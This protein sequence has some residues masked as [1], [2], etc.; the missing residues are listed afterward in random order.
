M[1]RF[2]SAA[3]G[4]VADRVFVVVAIIAFAAGGVLYH[5]HGADAVMAALRDDV[6][7]FTILL[8]FV[9]AVLL[10]SAV[11]EV[12]MPAGLVERWIGAQSGLRGI[13][14][15]TLA[16]MFTPGGPFVAFPLVLAL[17]RAGADYGALVA[18][19][20]AWSLLSVFR[21]LVFEMPFTGIELP[22]VRFLTCFFLPVLVGVIARWLSG[23][24]RPPAAADGEGGA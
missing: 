8:I 7:L 4:I 21:V 12:L 18:Y 11:I 17:L 24:W 6:K 13:V 5:L 23:F 15:A 20:T 2:L 19:V 3:V 14:L 1:H 16:G 22:A 9:P 10:L